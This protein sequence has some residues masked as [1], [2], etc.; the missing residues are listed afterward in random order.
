MAVGEA[1]VVVE[2]EVLLAVVIVVV[3]FISI[4]SMIFDMRTNCT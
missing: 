1:A 2:A 3:V 4:S